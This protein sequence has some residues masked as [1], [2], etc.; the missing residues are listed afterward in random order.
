MEPLYSFLKNISHSIYILGDNT[1]LGSADEAGLDL[2]QY[3]QDQNCQGLLGNPNDENSVAWLLQKILNYIKIIGPLLVIVLSSIDFAK[4][5]V[6]NDDDALSKAGKKL[7]IRLVLA[8]ALFFIPVL[9]TVLL[10][11]FGITGD[12]TCNIQ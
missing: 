8:A 1:G 5:I 11:V 10:D 6:T 2:D 7:G 9:A 12:P 4:V 3:N